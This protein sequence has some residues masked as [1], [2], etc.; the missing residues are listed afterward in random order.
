MLESKYEGTNLYHTNM[1]FYLHN[2]HFYLTNFRPYEVGFLEEMR[3]P[4]FP[5]FEI[6]WPLGFR[7]NLKIHLSCYKTNSANQEI[8]KATMRLNCADSRCFVSL[9]YTTLWKSNSGLNPVYVQCASAWTSI[10]WQKMLIFPS[11]LFLSHQVQTEK[12]KLFCT[13]T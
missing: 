13:T 3:T 2:K 8:G 6:I 11:L 1:L 9:Y 4:Q 7:Q 10:P 5:Q 12:I